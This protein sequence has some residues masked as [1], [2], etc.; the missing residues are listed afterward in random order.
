MARA[1][2]LNLSVVSGAGSGL[3]GSVDLATPAHGG[4]RRS[5]SPP[6]WVGA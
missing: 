4:Y 2:R 3:D 5:G 6:C 1:A